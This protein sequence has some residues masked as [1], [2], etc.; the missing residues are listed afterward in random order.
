MCGRYSLGKTG[1]ISKRY[2]VSNYKTLFKP[3]YN[4]SPGIKAP[5]IIR[6]SPNRVVLM[7]WGLIP[8]WAKDISIGYKMINARAE[9]IENK[10]AFRRPLRISRCLVPSDGFYEWKRLNLEGKEEKYPW[11]IGLKDQEIFSF[12]GLFDKWSDAEGKEIYSYTIITCEP[13]DL[14]EEIHNRM[15][16]I[17]KKE[18]ED[19]WLDKFTALNDILK[20]LKTYPAED[21]QSYPVSRRVNNPENDDKDLIKPQELNL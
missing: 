1:E 18:D 15:P 17:L 12:A 8:F 11:Y 2:N 6:Q 4:I 20:L 14:L 21:L 3:S 10:P 7:R 5:V 19:K 16:V 9:G 13:N